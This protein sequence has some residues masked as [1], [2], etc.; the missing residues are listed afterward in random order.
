MQSLE[1][2]AR[3]AHGTVPAIERQTFQDGESLFVLFRRRADVLMAS[4]F[5]SDVPHRIRMSGTPLCIA[6]WVAAALSTHTSPDLDSE[7]FNRLWRANVQ[8][9]NLS[10][11]PVDEAWAIL[12][13][14]AGRT[15]IVVDMRRLRQQLGRRQPS[16]DICSAELGGHGPILG[17]IHASKGRE[18]DVVHLM[19]P[20]VASEQ[21]DPE[22]EARVLFVAATRG[23]K[24]L[25]IGQGYERGASRVEPSGR[26]FRF[27][28]R[29]GDPKVQLEIGRDGDIGAEGLTGRTL[30]ADAQDATAAQTQI[31]SYG[32]Q[33]ARV[34]ATADASR[35]FRYGLAAEGGP[36]FAFLQKAVNDDLFRIGEQMQ[37]WY[38]GNRRRP[39]GRIPHLRVVALRSVVLPPEAPEAERLHAPW[40]SSGIMLAPVVLGFTTVFLPY[41]S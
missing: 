9:F 13:R 14:L 35:D 18:A 24:R 38:G 30:F 17:T 19:L 28:T 7:T 32:A 36:P 15:R 5:L 4:A 10:E 21:A 12:I 8:P 37:Q 16:A 39:P 26:I 41:Y 31:R 3:V 34:A 29:N 33:I 20:R 11:I 22:E 23:R 40:N 6:P 27:L 2:A 1:E 25:C